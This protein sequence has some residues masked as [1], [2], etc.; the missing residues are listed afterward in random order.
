MGA[1]ELNDGFNL[2]YVTQ[3][4]IFFLNFLYFLLVSH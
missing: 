4:K 3:T 2:H 1:L